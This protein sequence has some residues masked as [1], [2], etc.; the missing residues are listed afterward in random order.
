MTCPTPEQPG[1]YNERRAEP[2]SPA[3][4]GFYPKPQAGSFDAMIS[5]FL[6]HVD[7]TLERNQKEVGE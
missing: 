6:R 1:H 2:I 3:P 5:L 7:D 4:T